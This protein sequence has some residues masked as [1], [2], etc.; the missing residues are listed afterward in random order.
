MSLVRSSFALV[1]SEQMKGSESRMQGKIPSEHSAETKIYAGIDVCK[2][3]LDVYL[4]PIG[5]AFRVANTPA[6]LKAP[7]SAASLECTLVEDRH[8][9]DWQVPSPGATPSATA[10]GHPVAVVNP[11]WTRF[12]FAKAIGQFATRPRPARCARAGALRRK[13]RHRAHSP[14]PPKRSRRCRSW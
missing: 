14:R 10:A 12:Q 5:Q 6:G 7:P 13:H 3:W 1:V 9:G 2:A 4:H 11:Q 8:G